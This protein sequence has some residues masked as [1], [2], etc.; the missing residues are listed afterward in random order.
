[1]WMIRSKMRFAESAKA[2][3]K[4]H[5]KVPE[6]I[7]VPG[8][9]CAKQRAKLGSLLTSL[10]TAATRR[11]EA[12]PGVQSQNGELAKTPPDGAASALRSPNRVR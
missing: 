5:K 4:K 11:S 6:A 12:E 2:D 9:F 7:N 3:Y 10:A 1:M 8:T